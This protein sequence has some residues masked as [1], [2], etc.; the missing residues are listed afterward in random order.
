M[1]RRKNA[2]E[3]NSYFVIPEGLRIDLKEGWEKD[4]LTAVW[5]RSWEGIWRTHSEFSRQLS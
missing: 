1:L 3:D 2:K 5:R 4:Y